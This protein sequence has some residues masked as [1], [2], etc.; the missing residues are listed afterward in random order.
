MFSLELIGSLCA[1]GNTSELVAEL[2][3]IN[4]YDLTGLGATEDASRDEW[5]E[6]EKANVAAHGGRGSDWSQNAGNPHSYRNNGPTPNLDGK[7]PTGIGEETAHRIC[8]LAGLLSPI[9]SGKSK[10]EIAKSTAIIVVENKAMNLFLRFAKTA[11]S[12]V[13]S[14]ATTAGFGSLDVL[15]RLTK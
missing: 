3:H 5:D 4:G 14:S 8:Q 10:K 6:D 13:V 2:A 7:G 1:C 12:R 9:P 15:C 11:T